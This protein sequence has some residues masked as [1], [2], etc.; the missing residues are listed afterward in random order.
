MFWLLSEKWSE[1]TETGLETR[2]YLEPVFIEK[3]SATSC[4]D[5]SIF[6]WPYECFSPFLLSAMSFIFAD[7]SA[8]NNRQ[9]LFFRWGF[10]LKDCSACHVFRWFFW[11]SVLVICLFFTRTTQR[12]MCSSSFMVYPQE[13]GQNEEDGKEISEESVRNHKKRQKKKSEEVGFFRFVITFLT[14]GL[15]V[16]DW[17][18]TCRRLI[19]KVWRKRKRWKMK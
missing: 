7:A 6:S 9:C 10:N 18:Q 13:I 2:W 15:L 1:K 3:W 8:V 17:M 14:C 12:S 19:T 11:G 5:E 16:F 4:G